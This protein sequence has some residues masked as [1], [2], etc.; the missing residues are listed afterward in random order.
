M[1]SE[2][3]QQRP[4]HVIAILYILIL[5]LVHLIVLVGFEVLTAVVMKNTILWDMTPYSL[6]KANHHTSFHA[7][8][9]LGLFDPEDG[10]DMFLRNV[11]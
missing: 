7:C 11:G 6:L 9:L 2:D 4:K 3:G 5:N 1:P 8:I 10:S